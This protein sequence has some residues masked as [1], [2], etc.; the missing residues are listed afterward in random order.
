MQGL[1]IVLTALL[2]TSVLLNVY[3]AKDGDL[4]D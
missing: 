2:I 3:L 4:Y 1:L